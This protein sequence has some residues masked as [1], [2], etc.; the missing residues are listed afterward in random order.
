MEIK[1]SNLPSTSCSE[2]LPTKSIARPS[3]T[4]TRFFAC[5]L[6]LSGFCGISYEILYARLLGNLIG[7]QMAVTTSIL[8]TFLF[9]IGVGTRFAYRLWRNLWLIEAGIGC[10]GIAFALG[11]EQLEGCLYASL[12]L[13]GGGLGSSVLLCS[14]LLSAPAF[15]IGCSLPLFAGYLSQMQP[16]RVF[17]K[18]Y[19]LYNFG[20]AVTVLV[21]EFWILRSF[22]LRGALIG[23]ASLNL[24]V[25]GVLVT[26]Y[27]ELRFVAPRRLEPVSF[28][29]GDKLA[30]VL[31]SVGSAV[32][33]LMM[34]KTAE[35]LLG[36]FHETF[37]LV[38]ATVLLGIAVGSAMTERFRI[39]FRTILLLNLV[40]LVWFLSSVKFAAGMYAS[41]YPEAVESYVLSILLKFSTLAW[42]MGLPAVTFGATIPALLTVQKDVARESGELL[43]FSS[44]AN[45][46]GFL[47][48]A[49][50]LHRAFDYGVIVLVVAGLTAAAL[51][52]R[53]RFRLYSMAPATAL[54]VL[55]VWVHGRVWDEN[56]LYLGHTSFHSTEDYEEAREDLKFPEK[57]KG[58]QDIFAINWIDD[59]PYFFINGYLS[60]PLTS[61]SEKIV[62]AFSS[63]FSPGNDRALVLGV[64]S[65]ATAGTVGQIFDH[66]DAV[67][68]N[69]AVLEN[70]YRMKQY[71]FDI[72]ENRRVT[73]IQ[74][75]AIHFTKT[76][77][78]R[79]ALII[80]TVTTPLYFS[81][82]K[83]YTHDF[84][85]RVRER[86]APGGVYVTW[87]D[88]RIGDRGLDIVLN[89][90]SRSFQHCAIGCVKASYFLLLCSSKPIRARQ[91][92]IVSR[93]GVLNEY[94]LTKHGLNPA[95]F[96]YGLL[97]DHAFD[98]IDDR[99]APLNTL[100]LPALEFAMT[101]LRKR[102]IS[103][104][105]RRLRSQMS[106]ANSRAALSPEVAWNPY[107]L[108][109]HTE[110]LLGDSTISDRWKTL[111]KARHRN[112]RHGLR[113]AELDYFGKL[114]RTTNTADAHH[115][116]GYR[117]MR[118]G[119]YSEAVREFHTA[120]AINPLRD[121]THF[122]LG[123]CF[124]R[125]NLPKA[126]LREYG[127]ERTVDPG[128]DDVPFR[129]GRV[130]LRLGRYEKALSAVD[131][132]LKLRNNSKDYLLRGRVLE[133]LGR[134][135]Q[136]FEAYRNAATLDPDNNAAIGEMR[137][138]ESF[139][140]T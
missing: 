93:T 107:Q 111:V 4:C 56:L 76:A 136:A 71:N 119:R 85:S 32:F 83:L 133:G 96:A 15:L 61:P 52:V 113:R 45:A 77:D 41:L 54:V 134:R 122:N 51:I 117:L 105:K 50:V 39:R 36:P 89:T 118:F 73:I 16:G 3:P 138:L 74:D 104:F 95:W 137:R 13:L 46:G 102:G 33:Q 135:D 67:E 98:L 112:F 27:G 17:A 63:I 30:L 140:K 75:D 66:T 12:P 70:L 22:G 99:A 55:A 38:L 14:L 80:N 57:Y 72:E 53:F 60:I 48:M 139:Q 18:A 120:L 24:C 23:I 94:F 5:L 20:A 114:A 91:P 11:T 37:A 129:I 31:V 126:A 132:A 26:V 78:Q 86:L 84:L 101:R 6:V 28:P 35:C 121:N 127:R 34:F 106:L 7:D 87:V 109:M 25:A 130:L 110:Q 124:E 88:S 116:Y 79:Y 65:G 115:K 43:F 42:I 40:G 10:C 59:K 49:F 131:E 2:L 92:E 128:D 44:I 97:T 62:G 68:I 64:G 108:L 8:M 82:S 123:A 9:G 19:T 90:V 1:A 125:L 103:R 47:L 29:L 81:S 21:I 58:Y 100:D 69:P